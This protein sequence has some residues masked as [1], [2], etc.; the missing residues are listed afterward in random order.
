MVFP[1][2][3][4]FLPREILTGPPSTLGT[5][6]PSHLLPLCTYCDH[7]HAR[8]PNDGACELC[9]CEAFRAPECELCPHRRLDHP[10]E[11]PCGVYECVCSGYVTATPRQ[12]A[13]K[14]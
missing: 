9:A 6:V 10:H 13:P 4:S 1:L 8:H 5:S 3:P 12:E 14:P 11:G 7:S 2:P